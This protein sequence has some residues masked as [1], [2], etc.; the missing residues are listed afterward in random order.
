MFSASIQE[1]GCGRPW[2]GPAEPWPQHPP[3]RARV[4]QAALEVALH[5]ARDV[6]QAHH[7]GK[8]RNKWCLPLG[9]EEERSEAL[10]CW[11]IERLA[12]DTG[13]AGAGGDFC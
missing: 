3:E 6:A 13:S 8:I 4:T 11:P 2:Q 12:R 10:P 7:L 1:G 9:E 5:R